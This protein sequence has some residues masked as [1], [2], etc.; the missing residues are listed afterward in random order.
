[1]R[2]SPPWSCRRTCAAAAS[3]VACRACA[4]S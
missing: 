4:V 1:L 2:R 3:S